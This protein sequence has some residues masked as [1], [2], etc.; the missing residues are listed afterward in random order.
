MRFLLDPK[1]EHTFIDEL[2]HRLNRKKDDDNLSQIYVRRS[3][4]KL[5]VGWA[6][7]RALSN[8]SPRA[9]LSVRIDE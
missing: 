1:L 4:R 3:V 8:V 7:Q 2:F 6:S 5:V 9:R